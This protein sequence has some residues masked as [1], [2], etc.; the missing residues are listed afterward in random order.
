MFSIEFKSVK[1]HCK[2]CNKYRK[3]KKTKILYILL[4]NSFYCLL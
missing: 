2:V 1:I 4:K 3:S